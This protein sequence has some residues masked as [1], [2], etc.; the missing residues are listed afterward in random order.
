MVTGAV[1]K[2]LEALDALAGEV[3]DGVAQADVV[4]VLESA[5]NRLDAEISRRIGAIDS[6]G[7]HRELGYKN[8]RDL[9]IARTRCSSGDAFRQVRV[10]QQL[11]GLPSTRTAWASGEINSAHV[12]EITRARARAKA[13]DDFDRFEADA[14]RVARVGRVEDL[15]DTLTAWRDALDAR[16]GRV[17]D[18]TRFGELSA[19]RDG[20]LS[21]GSS[22]LGY[23]SAIFDPEGRAI[24]GKAMRHAYKKAHRQG[25]ARTPGQQRADAIVAICSAYLA[26]VSATGNAP[27][28]RVITDEATLAARAV[29]RAQLADGT[30]LSP[31]TVR[32]IACNAFRQDVLL[33][34]EGVPLLLGR[35]RRRFSADQFR[36]MAIRDGGCRG[37]GCDRP[38]ED[39]QPHHL[40]FWGRDDGPTDLGNGAL[41]CEYGC[42]RDVHEGGVRVEGNPD[43]ELRFY[44]TDGKYLGSSWPQA[45]PR[46]F[47]LDAPS[48][49]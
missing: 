3:I 25:D 30:R 42:H 27:H 20:S 37:P 48:A 39:C 32:R 7:E 47:R 15:V 45:A 40:G 1:A 41:F 12:E 34:K 44:D 22:G 26:G 5:A 17:G 23:L 16:L 4:V 19:R 6:H 9:L 2:L 24:V 10:S 21:T 18:E 29:G 11:A 46:Q 33:G 38:P 14:L 35:K 31:E 49:A 13:D 28:L 43:G 8:V 36:A